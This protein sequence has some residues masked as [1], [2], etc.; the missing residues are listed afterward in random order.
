MRAKEI[1]MDI[2]C[3]RILLLGF[4]FTSFIIWGCASNSKSQIQRMERNAIPTS[5]NTFPD[6]VFDKKLPEMTG[7]EYE[8]LGD[9]LLSRGKLHIAYLQYERSLQ[10]NPNNLRA[11]YKKGLALLLGEKN[12]EAIE[13]FNIILKKDAYFAIA[14][15][16][17]GRAYF[18]KKEYS[19]AEINFQKALK[20]NPTL[21]KAF[22]FLGNIYDFQKRFEE[23]VRAYESA[24]VIKP[25]NGVLYNNLGISYFLTGE[26]KKAVR[27][28]NRAIDLKYTKSKVYNNLGMAYANL[29]R[30]SKAL[31]AFKQAGGNARAYNNLGCIYLKKSMYEEALRCFEK[32]I[33]AQPGFY[34]TANE[35]L[36]KIREAQD[37][38]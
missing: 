11:E 1:I 38:L 33:E 31:Q 13:Q 30:Y 27:A 24:L 36:K 34:A 5:S 28:F 7:D 14:Y 25:D 9:T 32:A 17:L 6:E 10:A 18:N 21:W 22:N 16:G 15:E 26:F 2:N 23:A 4:I 19:E 3:K 20:M 12:D 8:R 29:E 35:N 37:Q